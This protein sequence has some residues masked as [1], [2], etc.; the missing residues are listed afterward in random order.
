M[1]RLQTKANG[2]ATTPETPLMLRIGFWF[3]IAIGVAVVVRRML[4]LSGP[5]ASGA[6]PE[7][8][9]LDAWFQVHAA[10]TYVHILTAL[11]FLVLLPLIFWHRTRRSSFVRGAYY[12]VGA[13][14]GIT[15]Y[16][17]SAYSVGGWVER[18][19]VLFFNTLFLITLGVGFRAWR[20]G[21][22]EEE[23]RWSLRSA[24]TVLGIATTRP[25]MGVFFATS[26]LTH[27][28]PQQFFGPAFWIGFSINVI[29][30]ELWLR[31]CSTATE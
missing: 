19:A 1:S 22:V 5:A 29:V 15:A 11:V 25:V 26:R 2:S 13:V 31:R 18:T 14:V 12:G 9:R 21:M 20:T 30:M 23:R 10:L 24:A 4:A 7:M 16:A 27:W 3:C 28:T 17:M 6:P 8:A